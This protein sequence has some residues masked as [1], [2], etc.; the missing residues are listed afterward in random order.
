[1]KLTINNKTLNGPLDYKN[2]EAWKKPP[3]K[4]LN[5]WKVRCYIYQCRDLPA[6]DSDGSSDPYIEAWAP[7]KKK[8][9]TAV[10][11][12]NC[13]PIYYSA[14][15]VF[16]DFNKKEE[17]PPIVLNIW[18]K[19]NDLLDST[20]DFLGRAV[21]FF[22]DASMTTDEDHNTPPEPRWHKVRMGFDPNESSIGE[23][24]CSFSLVPDDFSFITPVN[25][26]RL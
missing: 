24:L 15:E 12:D 19:D 4:R 25:Y 11:D 13:N 5:A 3:P 26:I 22:K 18:D 9:I 21:I 16:Y 1:M 23:I 17:A 14:L 7:D 8:S 6:A 20:D 2:L 10:V